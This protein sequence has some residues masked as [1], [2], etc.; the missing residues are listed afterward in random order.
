[1][2]QDWDDDEQYISSKDVGISKEGEGF[3]NEQ[4]KKFIFFDKIT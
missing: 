3:A 2:I 4:T 1:M